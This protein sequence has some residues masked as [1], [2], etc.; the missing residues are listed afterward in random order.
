MSKFKVGDKV[1][2]VSEQE[3]FVEIFGGDSGVVTKVLN[4]GSIQVSGTGGFW[5]AQFFI[6][7]KEIW[8]IYSN[9][10]PLSELSD[11]QRGLLFNHHFNGGGIVNHHGH[12]SDKP[13]WANTAIYRA[14]QKSERE[15][16]VDA[17]N[18]ALSNTALMTSL[19]A[20]ML[21]DSGKFEL[22]APKVGE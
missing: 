4:C 21:F 3:R 13:T 16:F 17:V 2:R 22:K 19:Y 6:I 7:N 20:E 8:S 1:K 15:L 5:D 12:G 10:L 11:E 14:K 9:T 18:S